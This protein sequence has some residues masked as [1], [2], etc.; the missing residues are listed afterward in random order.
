M[1]F[2]MRASADNLHYGTKF[3]YGKIGAFGYLVDET[4]L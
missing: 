2:M 4:E 3:Y 1:Q